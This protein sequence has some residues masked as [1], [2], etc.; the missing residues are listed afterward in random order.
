MSTFDYA[1]TKADADELLEEFGQAIILRRY[2]A[3]G[4]PYNPAV[5]GPYDTDTV[6][7]VLDYG[8]NEVDGTRVLATDKKVLL[9]VGSVSDPPTPARK[10]VIGGVEHAIVSVVTLAP[11]GTPVMWTLQVRR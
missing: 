5:G 11:A 8:L 10:V 9:A 6:G 1:E 3:G 4:S 2:E 7:V